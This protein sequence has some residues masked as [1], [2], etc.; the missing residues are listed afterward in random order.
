MSRRL[1]IMANELPHDAILCSNPIFKYM[2]TN[3]W[4][5]GLSFVPY[6]R[7][8]ICQSFQLMPVDMAAS[9]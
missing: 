9:R 7:L 5:Q 1:Q 6:A 2:T 8:S 4:K 3:S